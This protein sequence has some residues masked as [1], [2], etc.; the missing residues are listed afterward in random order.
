M[1]E[2]LFEAILTE[3]V[4]HTELVCLHLMG[5]PLAHQK[6]QRLLQI[7]EE[8]HA[9]VFLV[10]NGVLLREEKFEWLLMKC[11]HQVNFSLHS[12]FDNYPD[13]D[14]TQ[15]LERIF[16]YT[17]RALHERPDLY[18]N[19]R[20]W[21]LQ[22]V[23]GELSQNRE[24]LSR[25]CERFDFPF[26]KEID[27]KKEKSLKIRNRLYLHFDT[28]FTWPSLELPQL[29][30]VGR[31]LGLKSHFGVLVDGTVVPCCLDK[32]GNIPLGKLP[33]H[34]ILEILNSEKAQAIVEGFRQRRL[35][36]PLCQRCQY[37]ERF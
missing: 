1:S 30:T 32:E 18:L 6:L 19:F 4:P 28:E 21:N 12:F 8:N 14:P 9:K 16:Q 24:M 5:E 20:L 15:Y 10:S 34:S 27:L 7:C 2:T 33:E 25:I 29:G 26:P 37:I 3:V 35:M 23:K 17:E 22:Q 31:C 11:L 36:E 13:K